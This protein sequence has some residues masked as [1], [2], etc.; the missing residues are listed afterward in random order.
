[1][2]GTREEFIQTETGAVFCGV[3]PGQPQLELR[4]TPPT[5]LICEAGVVFAWIFVYMCFVVLGIEPGS[6]Y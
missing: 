4:A 5:Q 1:M 2:G 6:L 3:I